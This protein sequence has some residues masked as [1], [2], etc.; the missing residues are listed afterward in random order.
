MKKKNPA[1]L[2]NTYAVEGRTSEADQLE[3]ERFE[4]TKQIEKYLKQYAEAVGDKSL[5]QRKYKLGKAPNDYKE[6]K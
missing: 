2:S 3:K 6:E 4:I 5:V 1:K